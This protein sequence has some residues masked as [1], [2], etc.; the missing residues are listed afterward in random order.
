MTTVAEIE[1]PDTSESS[2]PEPQPQEPSATAQETPEPRS[3]DEE[4]ESSAPDNKKIATGEDPATAALLD[5]WKDG[6]T[7]LTSHAVIFEDLQTKSLSHI[8]LL[9]KSDDKELSPLKSMSA[10]VILSQQ[11]LHGKEKKHDAE[12]QVKGDEGARTSVPALTEN[13]TATAEVLSVTTEAKEEAAEESL[14]EKEVKKTANN[15]EMMTEELCATESETVE[16]AQT[17][18]SGVAGT[19]KEVES[20][21]TSVEEVQTVESTSKTLESPAKE[22][23]TPTE[24]ESKPAA[25]A[26]HEEVNTAI[27]EVPTATHTST[28]NEH[29][30]ETETHHVDETPLQTKSEEDKASEKSEDTAVGREPEEK[31]TADSAVKL[32]QS[33]SCTTSQAELNRAPSAAT[34]EKVEID[35]STGQSQASLVEAVEKATPPPVVT[36]T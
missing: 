21:K 28:E 13:K 11:A 31:E 16:T 32:G 27:E 7:F 29:S 10:T 25:T 30:V 33:K 23:V 15:G 22:E 1:V 17:E 19:V 14:P 9:G 34:V 36:N 35:H 2:Q 4:R 12:S 18:A 6:K 20:T 3:G 5:P 24:G 26:D 8:E